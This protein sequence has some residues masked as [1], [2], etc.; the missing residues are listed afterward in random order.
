[1]S[2]SRKGPLFTDVLLDFFRAVKEKREDKKFMRHV[3]R[4]I[5]ENRRKEAAKKQHTK[6]HG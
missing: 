4:L 5:D 3:D 6:T 2:L 1:M